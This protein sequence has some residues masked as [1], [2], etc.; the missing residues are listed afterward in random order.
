M[1]IGFAVDGE[2]LVAWELLTPGVTAEPINGPVIP[3]E[4]TPQYSASVLI[5]ILF[6]SNCIIVALDIHNAEVI[7][8]LTANGHT[9]ASYHIHHFF[10]DGSGNTIT[11]LMQQTFG[12]QIHLVTTI[13]LAKALVVEVRFTV[14]QPPT[15]MNCRRLFIRNQDTYHNLRY[16]HTGFGTI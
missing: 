12:M 3:V 8:R 15:G 2:T 4:S 13:I 1:D 14:Q 16:G 11:I 9:L 7:V 10:R 5:Y 6:G